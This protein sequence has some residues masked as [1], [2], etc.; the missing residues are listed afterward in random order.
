MST[1]RLE[2]TVIEGG[3]ARGNKLDRR[4]SH[5]ISR[6]C[7]RETLIR[8][9][10]ASADVDAVD[11][12]FQRPKV[13]KG[14]SDRLGPA[15]R[16]LASHAGRPWGVVEG[17]VR[18][19]FDTRSVSGRHIVFDHLLP[20]RWRRPET[21]WSVAGSR[22]FRVDARGFLRVAAPAWPRRAPAG[23]VRSTTTAWLGERRIALRSGSTAYWLEP[24]ARSKD[25]DAE[26][27]RY[28]QCGELLAHDYQRL[29]ELNAAEREV[30]VVDRT[31]R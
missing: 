21:G 16:W 27:R 10:Q 6:R 22:W 29:G 1:K 8:Y 30:Y 31:E 15:E 11:A 3:R 18:A 25:H 13:Y 7:E 14:F 19:V 9:A 26:S 4:R 20:G 17:E 28:R 12:L 5:R 24:T 23:S 2:R